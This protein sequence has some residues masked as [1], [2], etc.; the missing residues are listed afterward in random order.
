MNKCSLC[1]DPVVH[2]ITTCG[3]CRSAQPEPLCAHQ[4]EIAVV[5][6]DPAPDIYR[7][8]KCGAER[9]H[10]K[11]ELWSREQH[12]ANAKEDARMFGV[13]FVVDGKR[14][15]PQSVVVV[16]EPKDPSRSIPERDLT[17][18][19]EQQGIFRKF[20]VSRVDGSDVV[21]G[22]H[23][24]CRY[25]VLDLDHDQH[26]P[27]AMRA[28]AAACASTHP[29]LAADIDREFAPPPSTANSFENFWLREG[30]SLAWD[31]DR[32]RAARRIWDA[33]RK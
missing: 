23:F 8:T 19:A 20:Q 10:E 24:G 22:K 9:K 4:F 25:F 29:E 30:T 32:K 33:A 6:L 12:M 27:A 21:G 5:A 16:R 13:G 26:A 3:R 17:K 14:V 7:C 2:G 15:S 31:E 18:P 28:Y 11:R 1:G